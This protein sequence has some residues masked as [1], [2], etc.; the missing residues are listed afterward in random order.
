MLDTGNNYYNTLPINNINSPTPITMIKAGIIGGEACIT[1]DLI[2]L[3][4]HHPDVELKW[5]FDASHAGSRVDSVF[6]NLIGDIDMSYVSEPDY[7]NIDVLF[8]P[9]VPD[10][11]SEAAELKDLRV[12]ALGN[13]PAGSDYIHGLPE[14]NRKAMVR[15]GMHVAIPAATESLIE[16]AM[17][18]LA[19]NLLLNSHIYVDVLDTT[20][21]PTTVTLDTTAASSPAALRIAET[22]RE[23]QSGFAADIDVLTVRT[24]VQHGILASI[25]LRCTV[26]EHELLRLYREFFDDHRF[27]FVSAGTVSTDA[28]MRTNKCMIGLHR[29]D[30]QLLITA[31]IDERLKGC[32]GTAVHA[33]N[34][35]FGLHE[36]TGF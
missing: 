13:K 5:I 19:K 8:V 36:R 34:L 22:M 28:V 18:P 25:H 14:L 23:L 4:L 27:T 33:M 21:G 2:R 26:D 11:N 31:A 24:P 20:Y 9:Y 12:I 29:Q 15:G 6:A 1:G 30:D 3:L 16:L 35:L 7:S 10:D 17:L 32:A